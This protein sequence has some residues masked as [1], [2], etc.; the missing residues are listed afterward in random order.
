MDAGTL[1][2]L[3]FIFMAAIYALAM[4]YLRRCR[5]SAASYGL[6]GLFALVLPVLG[7]FLVIALRPGHSPAGADLERASR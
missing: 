4:T 2:A 3:L 5:L 6:W 1:R 7:P